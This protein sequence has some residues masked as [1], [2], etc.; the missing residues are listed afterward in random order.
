M[1]SLSLPALKSCTNIE[2]DALTLV[3]SLDFS[4]IADLEDL[5]ITSAYELP[6]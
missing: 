2:I 6:I 1:E 4:Q 3:T 5:S